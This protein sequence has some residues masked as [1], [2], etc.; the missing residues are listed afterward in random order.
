MELA[1]KKRAMICFLVIGVPHIIQPRVWA[2][3]FINLHR[4]GTHEYLKHKRGSTAA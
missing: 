2:Q 3:F 1:V 4:Q